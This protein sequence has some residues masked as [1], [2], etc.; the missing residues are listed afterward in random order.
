MNTLSEESISKEHYMELKEQKKFIYVAEL[1]KIA[2][3][4]G[5]SIKGLKKK[6]THRNIRR[7]FY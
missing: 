5:L 4:Y 7:T 6:T 2:A 3:N 1:K